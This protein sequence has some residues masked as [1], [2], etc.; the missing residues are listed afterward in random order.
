MSTNFTVVWNAGYEGLPADTE[1]EGQGATRIRDLKVQLR[2]RMAID[3]SWNGTPNDG[4]HQ[5]VTLLSLA[6][7]AAVPQVAN[8][9]FFTQGG[10]VYSKVVG[11]T[12]ELCY[13]D[14]NGQVLQLTTNGSLAGLPV[15]SI[16]S[17]SKM[18]FRMGAAPSGWTQDT[19][20]ND[21]M[22]R[23]VNGNTVGTGGN[24]VISGVS[25]GNHTLVAAEVPNIAQDPNTTR[26]GGAGLFFNT[27]N[28]GGYL[29]N[30]G[31]NGGF[32]SGGGGG[33]HAHPLTADGS[34]RPAYA[35]VILA[36]KN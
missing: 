36:T 10:V 5:A 29:S 35:D 1:S 33:P 31:N 12:S 20:V 7:D 3:H 27:N 17:G 11:G 15:S 19:S 23:F 26:Q 4:Y 6:G 8:D 22:L 13:R 32:T 18:I 2:T 30:A 16:P 28:T 21:Q 14:S 24:W 34:W 9:G 25:V